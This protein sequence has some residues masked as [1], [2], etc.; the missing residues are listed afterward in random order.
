MA[1]TKVSELNR[2][3]QI[4]GGSAQG[5]TVVQ[6]LKILAKVIDDVDVPSNVVQTAQVI[7]YCNDVLSGKC[8]T[9]IAVVDSVSE[10]AITGATITI[11]TG[12]TI[13]SGDAVSP[14][15]GKYPLPEGAYNYSVSATGYTT[16]TGTFEISEAQV[17]NGYLTIEIALVADGG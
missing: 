5:K 7:K 17:I 2:L 13:G 12:S 4:K 10:E 11:K 1:V 14:V 6:C 8:Q 3:I 16:K 15:S 9:T